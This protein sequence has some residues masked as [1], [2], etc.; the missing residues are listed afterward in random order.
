MIRLA[1][2]LLLCVVAC[3]PASQSNAPLTSEDF[4]EDLNSFS[5]PVWEANRSDAEREEIGR[6]HV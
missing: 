5:N 3:A 6:A 4:I 1:L 2:I